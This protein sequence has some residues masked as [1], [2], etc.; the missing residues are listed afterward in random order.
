MADK[1]DKE[2]LKELQK[3]SRLSFAEIGRKINLSPSSVRERI[4][5]M[6]NDG[7]IKRYSV[8]LDHKKLGYDLEVFLLI[9]VFHGNLKSFL[10]FVPKLDELESA[11]MITG[12][13]SLLLKLILKDQLHLQKVIDQLIHFGDTQTMLTLTNVLD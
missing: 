11:Y 10:K 7:L 5:K 4:L 6:E 12:N 8:V 2:I 3:D 1:I 13:H 9:K